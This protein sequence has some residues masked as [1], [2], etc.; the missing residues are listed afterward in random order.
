METFVQNIIIVNSQNENA[1]KNFKCILNKT[2]KCF[3]KKKKNWKCSKINY[4]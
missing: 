1:I 2:N 4:F 3:T